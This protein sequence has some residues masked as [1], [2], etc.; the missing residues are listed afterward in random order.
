MAAES[1]LDGFEDKLVDEIVR[2]LWLN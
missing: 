2:L 1:I